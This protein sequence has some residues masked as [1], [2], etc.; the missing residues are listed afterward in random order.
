ME[1]TRSSSGWWQVGEV[2]GSKVHQRGSYCSLTRGRNVKIKGRLQ[3]WI[4]LLVQYFDIHGVLE[5]ALMKFRR[6]LFF[7]SGVVKRSNTSWLIQFLWSWSSVIIFNSSPES[8]SS[9]TLFCF[10]ISALILKFHFFN[11]LS[12]PLA[13]CICQKVCT[14]LFSILGCSLYNIFILSRKKSHTLRP[15]HGMSSNLQRL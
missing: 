9:A 11:F 10:R 4:G 15:F 3:I 2:A 8:Q 14:N 7:G 5:I 13:S 12:F 1:V 6:T